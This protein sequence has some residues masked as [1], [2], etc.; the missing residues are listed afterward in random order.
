VSALTDDGHVVEVGDGADVVGSGDGASNR[1]LL[2]LGA[3]LDA[4]AGEVGSTT[5]AC[6]EAGS[7]QLSAGFVL[8]SG[9]R[10]GRRRGG[11]G[12]T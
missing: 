7:D 6:L 8:S 4:L 5:L 10:D 9:V 12:R 1:G 3:V 2:L 11:S